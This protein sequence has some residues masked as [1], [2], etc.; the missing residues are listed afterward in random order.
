MPT[1]SK[2]ELTKDNPALLGAFRYPNV[3]MGW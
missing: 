1:L 3:G 2:M